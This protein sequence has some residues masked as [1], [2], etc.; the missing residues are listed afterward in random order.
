VANQTFV[1]ELRTLLGAMVEELQDDWS[2]YTAEGYIY[3]DN[4]ITIRLQKNRRKLL[5]ATTT[6]TET[7]HW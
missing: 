2:V 3:S 7:G 6:T 4:D 1:V 5:W